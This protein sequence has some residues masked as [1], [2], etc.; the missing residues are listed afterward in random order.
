VLR[1]SASA[2]AER[3]A[4]KALA[5]MR[6]GMSRAQ[7]ARRAQTTPRTVQKYAQSA[8][9]RHAS[10]YQASA[11]DQLRRS[12]RFLTE[13][14]VEVIDIRSSRT[15]SRVASYWSAVDHYLR[16][17]DR[18][19]LRPFAG[20]QIRA[21]GHLQPFVTDPDTIIRFAEVGEVRF[22]DLYEATA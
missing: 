7:A 22:E 21:G 15:A 1:T 6:K 5:L 17:G 4:L 8:I 20:K 19:R 3:R 18:S 12:L 13:H 10:T 2:A 11:A 9:H 14:G 16:T